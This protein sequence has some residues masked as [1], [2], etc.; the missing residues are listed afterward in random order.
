V[1]E[2]TGTEDKIDSLVE[3]LRPYGVVEMVRTGRGRRWRAGSRRAPNRAANCAGV[4]G[5][6]HQRR[7]QQ[8]FGVEEL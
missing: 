5:G 6:G 8:L 3:V 7:R 1:I 4:D 2:T